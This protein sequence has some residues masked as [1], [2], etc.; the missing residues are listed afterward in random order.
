MKALN[1]AHNNEYG[2]KPDIVA[3][4]PGR[5]HLIGEHSC[6]KKEVLKRFIVLFE[7]IIISYI[8]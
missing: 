8:I 4:A 2:E 6:L 1:D 7:E 3:R 5:F